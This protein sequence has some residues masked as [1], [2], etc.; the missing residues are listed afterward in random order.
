MTLPKA[1]ER[2]IYEDFLFSQRDSLKFKKQR[3]PQLILQ[4]KGSLKYHFTYEI[5]E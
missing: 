1:H 3:V 4:K 5:S 2:H